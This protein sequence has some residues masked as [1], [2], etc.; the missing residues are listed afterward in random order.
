MKFDAAAGAR[1]TLW[2]AATVVVLGI[3]VTTL[4][5]ERGERERQAVEAGL[6][7][8]RAVQS[9]AAAINRDVLAVDLLLA[10]QSPALRE[11]LR[12]DGTLDIRA[13]AALTARLAAQIQAQVLVRDLALVDAQSRVLAAA[14]EPTRVDHFH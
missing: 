3:G 11:A 7:L 8:E 9:A 1:A 14:R 4:Q 12:S 5:L 10:A 6:A 2:A 13:S